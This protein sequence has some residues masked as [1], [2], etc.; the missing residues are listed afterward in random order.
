MLGKMLVSVF[1]ALLLGG[2]FLTSFVLAAEKA[3]T[4]YKDLCASCHGPKGKGDGPAAAAL[5]PK[6]E[7]FCKSKKHPTDADKYKMI[8]E[9]GPSMGHSPGMV[10]FKGAL[11]PQTIKELVAY[12]GSFCKK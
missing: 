11:D 5:N 12:I 6:P 3:A 7:D 8:A 9:G 1:L 10:S 4:V 2:G